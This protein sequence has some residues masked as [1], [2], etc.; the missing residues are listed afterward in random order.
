[1]IIA[2]SDM[3]DGEWCVSLGLSE[4]VFD[5]SAFLGIGFIH[6]P[7]SLPASLGLAHL[8]APP[9]ALSA[10]HNEIISRN[11]RNVPEARPCERF[12]KSGFYRFLR[13]RILFT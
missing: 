8:S 9:K 5:C 7:L 1:M 12:A 13:Q 3:S 10:P 6:F 2:S 11:M 4:T